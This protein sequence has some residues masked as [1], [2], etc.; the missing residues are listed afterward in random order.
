MDFKKHL[1]EDVL[2]FWLKNGIDN[3]YGGIFTCLDRDGSVYGTEKSVWFQ[4]RALWTFSKAYTYIE[5]REEYLAAARKLYDFLPLCTEED[6]RMPFLVTREG[7]PIQKRRYVHSE[8]FAAI[9]CAAFYK[10]T[11]E[12]EAWRRA[13]LYF[14]VLKKYFDN[15]SLSVPKLTIE[16]QSHSECMMMVHI[17]RCMAECAPDPAPYETLAREYTKTLMEAGFL[18]MELPGM[19]EGVAPDGSF[20]DT[21]RG[22]HVNPGHALETAW[23]LLVEGV[24]QKDE[25][26]LAFAK[27][28]ID[29]TLPLG[30][31]EKH[32][33]I[34]AFCDVLGKPATALEWDMKLWWPQ[35]EA[36][37]ALL[38]AYKIFGDEKYKA[39]YQSLLEFTF[40]HFP[41]P[42]YGEWFGYLHYD[43]T[44]AT[45]LK[46]N[47]FKGPFHLPRMLM[48]LHSIETNGVEDFFAR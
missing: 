17:A 22:R 36:L 1:T 29:V 43:S 18:H 13:E 39:Q 47:T 37:I 42:E 28:I 14:S 10:A 7:K 44:P 12:E 25:K 2:P 34:I 27:N 45:Y 40:T 48:L 20:I 24:L 21:P 8:K 23:F 11:G 30:L 38:M 6:G 41:D 19:L 4:G 9:G 16:M 46:G 3:E 32:G 35:N 31:D 15:P 5:K 33:G 26:V